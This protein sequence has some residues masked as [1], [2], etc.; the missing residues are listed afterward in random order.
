MAQPAKVEVPEDTAMA[1]EVTLDTSTQEEVYIPPEPTA[2]QVKAAEAVLKELKARAEEYGASGTVEA[3]LQL[4]DIHPKFVT[5][6]EW[7]AGEANEYDDAPVVQ[8][9]ATFLLRGCKKLQGDPK[10]MTF[11]FRNKDKWLERGRPKRGQTAK[12]DTRMQYLT[13]GVITS[14]EVN[15]HHWLTL[16]PLQKVQTIYHLLRGR[17]SSGKKVDPDFVGYFD[18]LEVFG[19]RTF[20]ELLAL[21]R[22]LEA[23]EMVELPHQLSLFDGPDEE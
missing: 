4:V 21:H 7:T 1:D 13:E 3:L 16:N 2:D 8:N 10:H 23:A 12:L 11:L 19:L 22:A 6:D 14:V 20:S 15:Y 5:P 17:D 9:I 18:E